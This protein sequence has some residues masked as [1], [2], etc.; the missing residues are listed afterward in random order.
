MVI[1]I[2]KLARKLSKVEILDGQFNTA[3]N[4][5]STFSLHKKVLYLQAPMR[6]TTLFGSMFA[7][8]CPQR[9]PTP[10][11]CLHKKVM[12]KYNFSK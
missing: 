3:S 9:T 6:L 2:F 12:M 4:L 5:T 11:P 1:N 7:A 10:T 8:F